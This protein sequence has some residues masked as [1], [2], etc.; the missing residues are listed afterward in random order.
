MDAKRGPKSRTA[1]QKAGRWYD[2]AT[3]EAGGYYH[4]QL[5]LPGVLRLLGIR[6][7]STGALLDLG[8][9]QGVLARQLPRGVEYWGVDAAESLIAAAKRRDPKPGRRYLL[10]DATKPL[11]LEKRDFAYA[12]AALSLQNME[13][14]RR[15][16]AN[17]GAHLRPGGKLALVLNHPCFRIPRQSR[18]EVDERSDM[19]FRRVDRY[20][21][22]LRIPIRTNP[23]L[24]ERSPIAWSFHHPLSD[25][26][27]WLA[28]AGL[29][30]ESIEEWV[31]DKKSEGKTAR[32]EDRSRQEFPLF[33]AV[34][35]LKPSPN[36]T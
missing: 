7:D 15:A 5:V 18:W 11:P 31:S 26:S 8:C 3:A 36:L 6:A 12:A 9:G 20:M 2:R 21:G 22:P 16:L 34:C 19:R 4:Q 25:Y 30:I 32:R 10:G 17:A 29:L 33:L 35:A 28:Q 1:W 27:R 13:E 23:S 14:P 24:G